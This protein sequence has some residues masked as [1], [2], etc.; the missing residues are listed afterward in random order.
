MKT[1]SQTIGEENT[2]RRLFADAIKSNIRAAMPGII[3]AFDAAS[4]TATVQPAIRE[5]LADENGNA[6]HITLPELLDVPVIMP[7]AGIYSITLPVTAGDECLVVFA[8]MCIDAWW[9]SG[10]VQNQMEQRRH[11]LSDA[12]A[13]L[14]PWSQPKKPASYSTEALAIS[15]GSGCSITMKSDKI[16]LHGP[17]IVKNDMEIK[18]DL[19]M[20]GSITDVDEPEEVLPL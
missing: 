14:G 16:E 3:T 5:V 7:H 9:Q 8:D 13:I 15:N 1:L 11:D 10:G 4:C 20:H 19:Y 6:V 12:F 2:Q 17:V 18:G